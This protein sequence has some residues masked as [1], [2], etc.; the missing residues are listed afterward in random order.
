M[1]F[2]QTLLAGACLQITFLASTCEALIFE[3]E[4]DTPIQIKFSMPFHNTSGGWE[5]H[6]WLSTDW[7]Q[8]EANSSTD[9]SI[10]S[11]VVTNSYTSK[12]FLPGEEFNEL[13]HF[14]RTSLSFGQ[15]SDCQLTIRPLPATDTQSSEHEPNN[16]P[17][18]ERYDNPRTFFLKISS[19]GKI[20]SEEW[21]PTFNN[22]KTWMSNQKFSI[23]DKSSRVVN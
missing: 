4:R 6:S 19:A 15:I 18:Q 23:N 21:E 8:I 9:V 17:S 20:D 7:V 3:N 22:F 13:L 16:S 5:N 10:E 1:K 14:S 2:I 11:L 12:H